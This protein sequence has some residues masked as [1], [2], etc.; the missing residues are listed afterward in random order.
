MTSREVRVQLKLLPSPIPPKHEAILIKAI[1]D[2]IDDCLPCLLGVLT[3]IARHII[4]DV[5]VTPAKALWAISVV[6]TRSGSAS[7]SSI[8]STTLP[9]RPASRPGCLSP[10]QG[11][12]ALSFTKASRTTR[13]GSASTHDGERLGR[14]DERVLAPRDGMRAGDEA[15]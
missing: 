12:S 9:S 5:N 3:L 2:Q 15:C 10:A 13:R 11:P 14:V 6:Q 1:Q 8:C 7:P 4:L